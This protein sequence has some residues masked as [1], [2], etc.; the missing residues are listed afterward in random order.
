MIH[1]CFCNALNVRSGKA[2]LLLC[3][4]STALII[5]NDN[6]CHVIKKMG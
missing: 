2:T 6:R 5:Y 4:T 1:V 3:S